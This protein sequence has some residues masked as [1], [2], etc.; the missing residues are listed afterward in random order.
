MLISLAISAAIRAMGHVLV[1]MRCQ[2]EDIFFATLATM[3]VLA[4][5]LMALLEW[6]RAMVRML[7]ASP[8]SLGMARAT[9]LELATHLSLSAT[10]HAMA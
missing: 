2:A 4:L 10:E 3:L 1:L 6:A 5:R 8:V 7:A 9:P